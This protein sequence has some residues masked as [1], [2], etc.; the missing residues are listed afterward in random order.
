MFQHTRVLLEV[1]P[2]LPTT[3]LPVFLHR[4]RTAGVL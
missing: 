2:A 3:Q 1:G 4:R